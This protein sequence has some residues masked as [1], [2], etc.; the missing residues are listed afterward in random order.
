VGF[1]ER[2]SDKLD[3]CLESFDVE[4][5]GS[6]FT[7]KLVSSTLHVSG[8]VTTFKVTEP[9][10]PWEDM[11]QVIHPDQ[12]NFSADVYFTL[13]DGSEVFDGLYITCLFLFCFTDHGELDGLDG[14]DYKSWRREYFLVVSPHQPSCLSTSDP[15]FISDSGVATPAA[16]RRLGVG[17]FELKIIPPP[18]KMGNF[19]WGI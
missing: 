18:R 5:D 3:M 7:S 19:T 15:I 13:D 12:L 17:Y 4:W 10:P 2:E 11:F 9:V 6:P 14:L 1:F 16:Y 8:V